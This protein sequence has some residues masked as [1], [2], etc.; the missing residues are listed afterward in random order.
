MSRCP[1]IRRGVFGR[2]S[3]L[4]ALSFITALWLGAA[5]TGH[6]V[7]QRGVS[8]E[9]A[10]TSHAQAVPGADQPGAVIVAVTRSGNLFLGADPVAPEA[11]T[12]R[13]R[14]RLARTSGKTV[15]VKAD[16][17]AASAAVLKILGRLS[18][19]GVTT[20][21]LLTGQHDSSEALPVPPKGL[22]VRIGPASLSASRATIR[23]LAAGRQPLVKIN[24]AIIPETAL[25]ARLSSLLG[26]HGGTVAVIADGPVPFGEVVRIVD[27]CRAAGVTAALT[28]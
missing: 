18:Q 13:V 4:W 1:D 14:Q 5:T 26:N 10:P 3:I 6:Q 21:I 12:D 28:R 23:V 2:L 27:L 7:L 17:R 8:V 20:P 25:P 19:A 16:A 15:Y 9:L 24:G 11:L 22:E